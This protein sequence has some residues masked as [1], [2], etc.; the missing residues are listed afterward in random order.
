MVTRSAGRSKKPARPNQ[1]ADARS[2]WRVKARPVPYV[3]GAVC[4]FAAVRSEN[5][6]LVAPS[7]AVAIAE[8]LSSRGLAC[9]AAD[10]TPI[11]PPPGV[12]GAIAGRS[13]ALVRAS[14]A[15]DPSDLY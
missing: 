3:L 14:A 10:V 13:R 7:P 15:G 12:S 8:V 2:A 9:V 6:D 4:V 5:L 1:A 11:D